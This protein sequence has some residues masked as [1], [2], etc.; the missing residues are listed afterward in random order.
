MPEEK[1]SE[2][3]VGL[4]FRDFLGMRK[5]LI[6]IIETGPVP[7]DRIEAVKLFNEICRRYSW[8]DDGGLHE[9][10]SGQWEDQDREEVKVD[11]I[12]KDPEE[13]RVIVR[14]TDGTNRVYYFEDPTDPIHEG[15]NDV[16]SA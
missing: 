11:S 13:G 7:S 9:Q 5:T 12:V 10:L 3:R 8:I 14:L 2:A 6:A 4:C 15:I 1:K 16:H